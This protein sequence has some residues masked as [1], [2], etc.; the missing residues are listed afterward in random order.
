MELK[1]K[2]FIRNNPHPPVRDLQGT[3]NYYRDV[4]GFTDEWTRQNKE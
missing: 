2:R 4:L 3:L 1:Q